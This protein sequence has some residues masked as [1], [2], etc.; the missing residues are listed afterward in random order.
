MTSSWIRNLLRA[1]PRSNRAP[2]SAEAYAELPETPV[3]SESGRANFRP[4]PDAPRD[5]R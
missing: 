2:K 4:P 3:R 1:W 5:S